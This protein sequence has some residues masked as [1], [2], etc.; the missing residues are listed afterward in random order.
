MAESLSHPRYGA[1]T[2]TIRGRSQ[3]S[4]FSREID[5]LDPQ[6]QLY[7]SRLTIA[8][9]YLGKMPGAKLDMRA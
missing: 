9:H 8:R 5:A 7:S 6:I 1:E 3:A 4:S 2:E